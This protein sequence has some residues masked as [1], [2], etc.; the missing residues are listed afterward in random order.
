MYHYLLIHPIYIYIYTFSGIYNS[1]A[2]T[3]ISL[4]IAVYAINVFA[5]RPDDFTF[6]A[7]RIA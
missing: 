6:L 4:F 3:S 1:D 5:Y 2:E 7:T